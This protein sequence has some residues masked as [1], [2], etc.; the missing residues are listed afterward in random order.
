MDKQTG[1]ELQVSG[2]FGFSSSVKKKILSLEKV[3]NNNKDGHSE[4]RE[5]FRKFLRGQGRVKCVEKRELFT[6]HKLLFCY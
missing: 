2:V 4:V 6:T 5:K 3:S 1:V